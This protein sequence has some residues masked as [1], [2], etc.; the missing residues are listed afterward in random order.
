MYWFSTSSLLQIHFRG[1]GT[2]TSPSMNQFQQPLK[3][4]IQ[5]RT[6]VP[7]DTE[8]AARP[9]PGSCRQCVSGLFPHL[10]LNIHLTCQT[11]HG[12][13]LHRRMLHLLQRVLPWCPRAQWLGL[14]LLHFN[15]QMLTSTD[16]IN[17]LAKVSV[18]RQRSRPRLLKTWQTRGLHFPK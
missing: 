5:N 6:E 4:S 2:M 15:S 13:V 8:G 1:R 10:I 16:T 18:S 7:L 14:P 11:R 3:Q 17:L 9:L 12:T